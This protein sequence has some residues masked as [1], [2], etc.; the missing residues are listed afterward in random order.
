M[1][2]QV[3]IVVDMSADK[4]LQDTDGYTDENQA[5]RTA[6]ANDLAVYLWENYI[7][8]ACHA[9]SLKAASTDIAT[10]ATMPLKFS[11]LASAPHTDAS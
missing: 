3:S 7:E 6:A 2:T 9:E 4:L 5:A 8:Y 10:A 11:S 1:Y